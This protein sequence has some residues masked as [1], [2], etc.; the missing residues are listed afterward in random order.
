LLKEIQVTLFKTVCAEDFSEITE[1]VAR[2]IWGSEQSA[3]T[4]SELVR[5][6]ATDDQRSQ[7]PAKVTPQI[8]NTVS[9]SAFI[10]WYPFDLMAM[11]R[12]SCDLNK[13]AMRQY[14]FLAE[15]RRLVD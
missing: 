2:I 11:G 8:F 9:L 10:I 14:S 3:N 6:G 4:A 15:E 1:R 13:L 7:C 12:L 5:R